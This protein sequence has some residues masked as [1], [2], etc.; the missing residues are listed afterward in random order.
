MV[1]SIRV[2]DK[3][4]EVIPKLLKVNQIADRIKRLKDLQI[5]IQECKT[6]IHL[7]GSDINQNGRCKCAQN[8]I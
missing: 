8:I 6:R 7:N 5:K 2:E 3:S 1:K 4:A